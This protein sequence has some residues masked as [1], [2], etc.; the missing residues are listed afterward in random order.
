MTRRFRTSRPKGEY[1]HGICT[2]RTVVDESILAFISGSDGSSHVTIVCLSVN[3]LTTFI[4]VT[5]TDAMARV[6]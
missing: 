4:E 6:R 3:V 5:L 1:H 2:E